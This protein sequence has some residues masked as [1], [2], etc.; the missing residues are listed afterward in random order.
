M[1]R[2]SRNK[3]KTPINIIRISPPTRSKTGAVVAGQDIT[4][5]TFCELLPVGSREFVQAKAQ[6]M[7]MDAKLHVD[8]ETDI[9]PSDK[10]QVLTV[11][12]CCTK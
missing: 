8:Y 3:L 6:G 10:V 7:S 9:I 11:L 4:T 5:Q 2:L 1:V 12:I